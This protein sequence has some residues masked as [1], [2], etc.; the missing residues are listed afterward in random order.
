MLDPAELF[1]GT[2]RRVAEQFYVLEVGLRELIIE[3]LSAVHGP[4]WYRSQLPNDVLKK[5]MDGHDAERASVWTNHIAHHPL[6]FIDFPDLLKTIARNWE[7]AFAAVF[8]NKDVVLGSFRSLE[9]IRNKLAHNRKI[10]E[11][12]GAVVNGV[13]TEV[14]SAIGDEKLTELVMRCTSAPGIAQQLRALVGDVEQAGMI[15]IELQPA[16]LLRHWEATKDQWWFD[17]GYLTGNVNEDR[18]QAAERRLAEA[19]DATKKAKATISAIRSAMD[20]ITPK[21]ADASTSRE[22][23]S[24]VI[25]VFAVYEE[26]SAIPRLRGTG[27]KLEHWRNSHDIDQLVAAA[28]QIIASI[29]GC[30]EHV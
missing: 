4:R 27:H 25:E 9:P 29:E 20:K 13:F 10:T 23:L 6:Y 21:N 19:E 1:P 3:K 11:A 16:A 24:A 28:R 14:S 2:N 12:D 18:L 15:M 5:Y 17:S 7:D 22:L 8:S 26:Y 30:S